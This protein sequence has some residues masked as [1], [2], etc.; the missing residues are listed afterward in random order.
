[1]FCTPLEILQG[2]RR[3]TIGTRLFNLPCVRN[4][5]T[6]LY[7]KQVEVIQNNENEHVRGTGQGE[8]RYRK[9]KTLKLG[10]S[11]A[12]DCSSD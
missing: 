4:Y 7:R 1:M 9:Y 6:K 11:Q 2:V 10:N 3:S 8:A 12:D 5:T